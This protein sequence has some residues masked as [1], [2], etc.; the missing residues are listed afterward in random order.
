MV[1][2]QSFLS[3]IIGETSLKNRVNPTM[4]ESVIEDKILMGL[5]MYTTTVS[6]RE[7]RLESLSLEINNDISILKVIETNQ[8]EGFV[9]QIIL[10]YIFCLSAG[11][12][13]Y[14]FNK[15]QGFLRLSVFEL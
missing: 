1:F 9:R 7:V 13:T 3:L 15:H 10:F 5:V 11:K 2:I 12:V 14:Q 4:I 6:A 8:K